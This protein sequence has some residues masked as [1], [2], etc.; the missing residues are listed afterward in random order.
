M[1]VKIKVLFFYTKINIK[2]MIV[3]M[4]AKNLR[5]V[6]KLENRQKYLKEILRINEH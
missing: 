5:G 1:S 4:V 3:L 6:F 2:K